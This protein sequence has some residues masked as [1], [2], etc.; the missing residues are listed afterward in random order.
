MKLWVDV[1][2]ADGTRLGPGPITNVISATVT[3]VLDGAGSFSFDVPGKDGRA[4][5]LIDNKRRVRL[6]CDQFGVTREL[7]RGIVEKIS[8]RGNA[9]S[10][11]RAVDGPDNLAEL[12]FESVLL[13]RKYDAQT[14]EAIVDDLLALVSGWT[15]YGNNTNLVS[16]RFDGA[17]VL[18]TLQSLTQQQGIHLRE[19]SAGVLEIGAMGESNGLRAV[20]ANPAGYGQNNKVLYIESLTQLDDSEDLVNWL[21]PLGGGRGDAALT[22]ELSTRT[23]PY[24]IYSTTGPDGRTLY[25]LQDIASVALNG[26]VAKVGTFKDIVPISNVIEDQIAAANALYDIAAAWLDRYKIKYRSYGLTCRNAQV[27]ILPGDKI[28]VRYIGVVNDTNGEMVNYVDVNEDMW[29]MEVRETYGINGIA[30]TLKVATID[31]YNQDTS[32]VLIGAL[33]ELRINNVAVDSYPTKAPYVYTRTLDSTHP[34]VVP[35]EF[36]NAT[37]RL[38]RCNMRL[39]TRPFQATVTAAASGGGV[40]TAAGGGQT[41]SAGGSHNHRM[42]VFNGGALGVTQRWYLCKDSGGVGQ[43]V[44]IGGPATDLY[45]FDAASDHTHSVVDHTHSV[46]AHTHPLDYGLHDDSEY[47]NTVRIAIDGV[48]YTAALGGPWGVGGTPVNTQIEIST[49]VKANGNLQSRHE[50]T[51]TCDGGQGEVEVTLIP[52]EVIQSIEVFT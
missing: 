11:T 24:S 39:L 16:A 21:L 48:D 52:V 37:A 10:W 36:D 6:F 12:K 41:S 19:R 25:Y 27:N 38:V 15:R 8:A 49:Q 9:A 32:E 4:L 46:P 35:L 13:G 51:I 43:N 7:T 18:K 30:T 28:R 40:T 22:L 17:S 44:D 50:I 20:N 23:A 1:Y 47:P 14:T 42:F 26:K 3:R 2:S 33:E 34:A 31:R 29:V 5:K 45:T